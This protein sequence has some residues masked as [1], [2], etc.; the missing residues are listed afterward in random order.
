MKNFKHIITSI[1]LIGSISNQAQVIT[2]EDSLSAGLVAKNAPTVISGYGQAKVEYD[3]KNRTG[4][5]NLTRNVLFIGHRFSNKI[6][7]F[8]LE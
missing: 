8:I 1:A 7:F 6:S 5:A 3:L 2:R 4:V